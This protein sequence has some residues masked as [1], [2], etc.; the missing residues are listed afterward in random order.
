MIF[1]PQKEKVRVEEQKQEQVAKDVRGSEIAEKQK[2]EYVAKRKSDC[3]QIYK[4]EDAKWNNVE[5]FEYIEKIDRC[6]VLYRSQ[7]PKRSREACDKVAESI[8]KIGMA[9]EEVIANLEWV[10][11]MNNLSRKPF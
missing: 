11:C 1:L 6:Y 3:L 7:E 9:D 10:D 2:K 5:S 4:T 8:R